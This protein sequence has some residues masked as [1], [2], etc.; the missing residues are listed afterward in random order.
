MDK[1]FFFE[2]FSSA[3]NL[4]RALLTATLTEKDLSRVTRLTTNE[5]SFLQQKSNAWI[6]AF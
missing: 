4:K 1:N 2:S 3:K 6:N 5:I